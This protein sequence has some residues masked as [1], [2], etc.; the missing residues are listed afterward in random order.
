[1]NLRGNPVKR[2]DSKNQ[3]VIMTVYISPKDVVVEFLRNKLTDVRSRASTSKTETFNGGGTEFQLT[4]TTGSVSCITSVSVTSVAQTKWKDYYID[5]QLEKI[6]FY[7]AT[8][9]GTLN[10][11]ITYKHGTTDWIYWDKA[12]KVL[13]RE[14]FPRI[15]VL[16]VNEPG[17]RV[18]QYNSDMESV[19]HFQVDIWVKEG[20]IWTIGGRTYEGD[21]HGEYIGYKILEAMH[22]SEGDLYPALYNYTLLTGPRDIGFDREMECFH[23]IVEFEMKGLNITEGQ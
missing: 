21:R 3:E 5:L 10:V 20:Q 17:A 15:N 22:D 18:G 1:L 23:K 7:S 19:I 12:K 4:P 11:S 9:A 6:V 13:G 2:L 8:A 16:I 14:Q